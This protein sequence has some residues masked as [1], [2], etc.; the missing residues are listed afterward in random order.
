MDHFE[1]IET[2]SVK[3]LPIVKDYADRLGL[4]E[5]VNHLVPSEMNLEPGLYFLG[6][7]L[8]TLS[9]R[10]PLYRLEE[11]FE[12]QD[13]ELLLG[14][15]VDAK[16]FND[17]NVGR[18]I[19]QVFGVG[20][21]KIF[22]AISVRAVSAFGLNCRHVHFDTTSRS[23]YGEYEPYGNDPFEITYG[24]SKDHRP[25]LKQFLISMLCVDR[26]VPI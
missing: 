25:D 21:V 10:N 26:N 7:V 12:E 5:L 2:Y 17:V 22:K 23:V 19:D 11:F 8:D 20:A 4:V 13:T 14:K 16:L 1:G 18:F 3:H 24:H 6:M 15:K 9:G